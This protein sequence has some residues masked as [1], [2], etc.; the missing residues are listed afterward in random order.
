MRVLIVTLRREGFEPW[1]GA[2]REAGMEVVT[3]A[4]ARR[5]LNRALRA[6]APDVVILCDEDPA[7]SVSEL[8]SAIVRQHVGV[9]IAFIVA[10][11]LEIISRFSHA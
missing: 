8:R 2:L 6:G 5:E 1:T 10:G 11:R 7:V 3:A 9:S 4:P